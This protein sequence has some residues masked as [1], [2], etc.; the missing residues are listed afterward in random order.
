MLP[1]VGVSK[2]AIIRR[3]VVLP[4]PEGP[5]IEKNSP[6]R[7]SR[8]MSSTATTGGGPENSLRSRD[9]TTA[10]SAAGVVAAIGESPLTMRSGPAGK[11]YGPVRFYASVVSTLRPSSVGDVRLVERND[12][13]EC[14][15][16]VSR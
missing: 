4:E 5:N 9:S 13:I 3:T 14:F 1:D 15:V 11:T 12:R 2:P 6:S 16:R 7:I 8:S 10:D